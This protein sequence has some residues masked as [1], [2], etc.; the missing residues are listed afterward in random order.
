M[1]KMFKKKW[2]WVLFAILVVFF[3]LLMALHYYRTRAS[4]SPPGEQLPHRVTPVFGPHADS[5]VS[6]K[7]EGAAATSTP[8]KDTSWWRLSNDRLQSWWG[9]WGEIEK[10]E[11]EKIKEEKARLENAQHKTTR[12]TI[13]Q[14]E[15]TEKEEA[16][17]D[18]VTRAAVSKKHADNQSTEAEN[19]E[20]RR[21]IHERRSTKRSVHRVITHI[22]RTEKKVGAEIGNERSALQKHIDSAESAHLQQQASNRQQQPATTSELTAATS[23]QKTSHEATSDHHKAPHISHYVRSSGRLHGRSLS[24]ST[25]VAAASTSSSRS[26]TSAPIKPSP[27]TQ[28][29]VNSPLPSSAS[30]MS[31]EHAA[32]TFG[33]KV[34]AA[35]HLALRSYLTAVGTLKARQSIMISA[36]LAGR[37]AS[38]HFKPGS[39]VDKDTL[40]V[41][42]NN[43]IYKANLKVAEAALLL[44]ESDYKRYKAL[45]PSGAVSTAE[46]QKAL[47]IYEEN[48]A[49]VMANQ[50]YLDET[51]L[52]APFAGYVGEKL[53]GVGSYV[54]KGTAITRLVDR[55]HLTVAYLLPERYRSQLSLGQSVV[56][57]VSAQEPLQQSLKEPRDDE[58]QFTE[59]GVQGQVVYIAPQVDS[60]TGS[61]MLQAQIANEDGRLSPGTFVQLKQQIAIDKDALVVPVTSVVTTEEGMRVY[62]LRD[63][64]VYLTK[65]QLGAREGRWVQIKSGLAAGELVVSSGANNL[66]DGQLVHVL[67]IDRPAINATPEAAAQVKP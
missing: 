1:L 17:K 47:S 54:A 53:V 29:A 37:I 20:S 6:A 51:R 43:R 59:Q 66:H 60:T 28:G 44:S 27:S 4:F 64:K 58:P 39:F 21:N 35:H 34:T 5:G 55:Q 15:K 31:S 26:S 14:H 32:A 46:V 16:A 3:S 65:V 49:K 50:A 13:I 23:E 18:N 45:E 62:R 24:T 61:V 42:L 40:L 57:H 33:V 30:S 48:K 8:R 38:F 36:E 19:T 63:G 25:P 22:E 9:R 41:Q 2:L 56:L 10:T 11:K 67:E 7:E 12:P 52:V